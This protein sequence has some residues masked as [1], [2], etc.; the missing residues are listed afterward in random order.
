MAAQVGLQMVEIT[1]LNDFYDDNRK[2]HQEQLKALKVLNVKGQIDPIQREV[3]GLYAAFVFQKA[4]A[5]AKV[6]PVQY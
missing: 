5:S 1:N 6:K 3:S 2:T 4:S